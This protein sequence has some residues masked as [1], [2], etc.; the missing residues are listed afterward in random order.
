MQNSPINTQRSKMD[1]GSPLPQVQH[2]LYLVHLLGV[3]ATRIFLQKIIHINDLLLHIFAATVV[4][5]LF[6]LT[7][8]IV[9]DS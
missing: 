1:K 2:Q 9:F 7:I 8:V 4:G 6:P 5:I 3:V